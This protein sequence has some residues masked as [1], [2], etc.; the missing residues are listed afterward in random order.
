MAGIR[1]F[2]PDPWPK[3]RHHKRRLVQPAFVALAA[4]RLRPG[5]TLHMATDWADYAEQMRAVADAEPL[6]V[7][8]E[9][10][11]STVAARDQVR[12]AGPR[13]GP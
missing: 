3:R 7:G 12:G 2:F 10:A 13:R 6:L 1:I 4:A 11:A 8:G 5:G 9:T